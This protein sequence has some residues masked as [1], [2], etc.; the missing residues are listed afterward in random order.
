MGFEI[1]K[2]RRP[3]GTRAGMVASLLIS[4]LLLG[5]AAA[6]AWLLI[7]GRGDNYL[8]GTLLAGELLLAGVN[9]VCYARSFSDFREVAEDREEELLW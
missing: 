2:N 7:T 6:F 5:T 1:L 8:L 9:L 4:L 3:S